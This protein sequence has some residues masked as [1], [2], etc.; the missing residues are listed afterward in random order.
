[1]L[2][3]YR[4]ETRLVSDVRDREVLVKV[5]AVGICA[6]DVKCY[7]GANYYWGMSVMRVIDV[8]IL[9]NFYIAKTFIGTVK[10]IWY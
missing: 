2:G 3:D 4:I 10:Y 7:E 9:D 8:S 6:S 1:M 5:L